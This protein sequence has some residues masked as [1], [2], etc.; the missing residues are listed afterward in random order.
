MS[1]RKPKFSYGE[2]VWCA[3]VA[4][5][6][7]RLTC[8]DCFGKKYLRVILGDDSEVTIDCPGCER[9]Y[10]GPQGVI[11]SHDYA[12]T[13]TARVVMGMEVWDGRFRYSFYQRSGV[14]ESCCFATQ[15]EASTRAVELQKE[16]EEQEQKRLDNKEKPNRTW[17]WNAT[18]HRG[19]LR[20]ANKDIEYHTK[21]LAMAL[22]HKKAEVVQHP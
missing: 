11:M 20:R 2:M 10:L 14:E 9:G 16:H 17:A 5:T 7:T 22:E 3:E 4:P 21:K 18:Y 19:C 15:E 12:A 8:P 1:N 6:E 13:V